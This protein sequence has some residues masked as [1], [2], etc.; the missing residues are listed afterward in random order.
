MAAN[1]IRWSH[2]ELLLACFCLPPSPQTQPK[3][4]ARVAAVKTTRRRPR[5]QIRKED[6]DAVFNDT[7]ARAIVLIHSSEAR[8]LPGWIGNLKTFYISI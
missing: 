2:N 7:V 4:C 3:T 6:S 5:I 1:K 8:S